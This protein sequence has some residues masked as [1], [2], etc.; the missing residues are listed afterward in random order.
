VLEIPVADPAVPLSSVTLWTDAP[1]FSRRVSVARVRGGE[2]EYLRATRWQGD[3]GPTALTFDLGQR[4]GD[5]LVVTLHDGDN[6]PLPLT[7]VTLRAPSW[8][9]VAA[10]PED[11]EVRLLTGDPRRSA[12]TYDLALVTAELRQRPL[13]DATLGE[14]APIRVPPLSWLDRLFVAGGLGVL[15]VGLLGLLAEVLRRT[16]TPTETPAA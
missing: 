10:L 8:E 1:V 11:V 12:P 16:A 2:L 15:A 7:D 3:G 4:I 13:A 9:L 14:R 6:P 5:T